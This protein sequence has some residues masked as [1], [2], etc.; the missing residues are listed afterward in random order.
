MSAFTQCDYIEELG[1][2][3]Q[4]PEFL[5]I[6]LRDS[7]GY[8]PVDRRGKSPMEMGN[9]Y[10]VQYDTDETTLDCHFYMSHDQTAFF[11]AFEKHAQNQGT[12]WFEMPVMAGGKISRHVV[13]FREKPKV[14]NFK[15]GFCIVEMSLDIAQRK[16]MPEATAWSLYFKYTGKVE[17]EAIVWPGFLDIPIRDGYNYQPADRRAKGEIDINGQYRKLFDTDE[18]ILNCNFVLKYNQLAFFEAFEKYILKQG[19]R[20]FEMPLLTGGSLDNHTVRFQERPKIGEFNG[21]FATVSMVLDVEA[22]NTYDEY[23]MW[24]MYYF[25][26]IESFMGLENAVH[27]SINDCG[28]TGNPCNGGHYP[29]IF[30]VPPI[31]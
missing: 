20:W 6:P 31:A 24:T 15:G 21:L 23:T 14:G 30:P 1:E 3:A 27:N 8:A 28:G 7:Y 4:W 17:G 16:T 13:R 10:R 9:R 26:G 12:T 25:G 22:R 11:E 5:D 29:T 19:S 2:F 18:T